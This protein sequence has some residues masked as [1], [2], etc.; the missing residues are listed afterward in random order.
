[1]HGQS[2]QT[3]LITFRVPNE[4]YEVLARRAQRQC[5]GVSQYVR[6]RLVYDTIRKHIG[7]GLTRD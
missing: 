3:T 7:K 2:R 4:V 5:R 1:M 6:R